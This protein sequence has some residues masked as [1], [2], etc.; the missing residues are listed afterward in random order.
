LI[1]EFGGP[2]LPATGCAFRFDSLLDDVRATGAWSTPKAFQLFLLAASEAALSEAVGLAETLRSGGIRT[3]V[4]V[5]P[6]KNPTSADCAARKTE[7]IGLV[8]GRPGGEITI[9]DGNTSEVVPGD[10]EA[11]LRR[12][13]SVASR[14][15]QAVR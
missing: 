8:S 10:A 11:L 4:A 3:G 6:Q 7:R 5:G 2:E 14:E 1:G 15:S 9:S 13:T 12:L